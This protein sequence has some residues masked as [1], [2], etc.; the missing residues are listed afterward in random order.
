[1]HAGDDERGG[2]R[3]LLPFGAGVVLSFAAAYALQTGTSR[4]V[5]GATK[6][7]AGGSPHYTAEFGTRFGDLV[8][9]GFEL[10]VPLA[11]KH[12]PEVF[13]TF[14]DKRDLFARTWS[15][16][17]GSTT[18]C[19]SCEACTARRL[20]AEIAGVSDETTYEREAFDPSLPSDLRKPIEEFH[21]GDWA[22]ITQQ[23]K[24]PKAG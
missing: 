18:Q 4:V 9:E 22:S 20:A 12:K 21:D 6:D 13:Q 15:C 3:S 5:W 19:G 14:R 11:E 24:S 8:G 10:K 7:D 23:L 1:M 2:E 17:V 16:K